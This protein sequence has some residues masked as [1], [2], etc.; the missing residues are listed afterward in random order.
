MIFDQFQRYKTTEIVID[1]LK[2]RL[3]KNRMMILEIGSNQE[4]NLEK[5]L[6]NDDIQYSDIEL[7]DEME[8]DKHFIRL[9]GCNMPEIL[10]NQYDVVVA[11][12]VLEHVPY[13]QREKFMSEVDRVAKY[14]AIVCFPYSSSYNESAE[15]RVNSYYKMI[16]GHDHKWLIEHIQNGLPQ[17]KDI[18]DLLDKNGIL[19]KEFY[20]GDIFLWEEMMKAMFSVYQFQNGRCYF[21]EVDKLYQ[22]QIYYSDNT[23]LSYRVFEIVSDDDSILQDVSN[24]IQKKY[25]NEQQK[26]IVSLLLRCIDDLKYRLTSG[27]G[28]N[29]RI[30]HQIYYTFGGDFNESNKLVL[31][32]E[33]SNE[34]IIQIDQII[35]IDNQY[36]ALRFDPVEEANCILKDFSI[37]SDTGEIDFQIV[38]GVY[39]NDKIVFYE[40][41]PQIYID[42]KDKGK[43]KWLHIKAEILRADFSETVIRN[44][45]SKKID[46]STLEIKNII[47]GYM[48]KQ[49]EI[50]QLRSELLEAEA[51]CAKMEQTISW[52]IT[53]ILRWLGNFIK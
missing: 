10:D 29:V 7:S 47:M 44:Q 38:N 46:S 4:C 24:G 48:Q 23:E 3:Q 43:L 21:E 8:N 52:K 42:L 33:S 49:N 41:D 35:N 2:E 19:H 37:V 1:I 22:E 30:Q 39:D 12:D 34:N 13:E 9:D 28:K 27:Y 51:R 36:T 50:E 40:A 25:T 18:S 6:P 15:N 26:E 53:G 11:L 17:I 14:M 45:I 16:F 31:F 5:V 20:H 32:S